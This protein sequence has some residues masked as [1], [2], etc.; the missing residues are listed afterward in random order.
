MKGASSGIPLAPAPISSA[1]GKRG[2]MLGRLWR[3][4]RGPPPAPLLLPLWVLL[5]LLVCPSRSV[6]GYYDDVGVVS[7]VFRLQAWQVCGRRHT[8]GCGNFPKTL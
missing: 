4:P 7:F 3:P 5:I 2:R 8:P 1:V 6:L